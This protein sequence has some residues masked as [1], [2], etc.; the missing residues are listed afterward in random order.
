MTPRDVDRIVTAL[1]TTGGGAR[2]VAWAEGA[3]GTHAELELTTPGGERL[4]CQLELTSK[5]NGW[6]RLG[7]RHLRVLDEHDDGWVV[8]GDAL[9]IG[10]LTRPDGSEALVM[11]GMALD[12]ETGT[13]EP[14]FGL[15]ERDP[16]SGALT[17]RIERAPFPLS[18]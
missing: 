17:P 13:R 7:Q 18:W 6:L 4:P 3:T 16:S 15:Y 1:D 12:T 8:E 10:I 11:E 14:L 9:R 2:V 5:G